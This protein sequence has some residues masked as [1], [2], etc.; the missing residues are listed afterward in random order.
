MI[1]LERTINSLENMNKE[2][3]MENATLKNCTE[4]LLDENKRLKSQLNLS[5][6]ET[7]IKYFFIPLNL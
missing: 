5:P 3:A 1:D 7:N 6:S 2:L 4:V